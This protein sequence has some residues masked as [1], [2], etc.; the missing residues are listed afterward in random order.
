MLVL[1]VFEGHASNTQT[2]GPLRT[3]VTPCSTTGCTRKLTK[4]DVAIFID[5]PQNERL[6]PS[7]EGNN[8]KS[9]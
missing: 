8:G 5:R 1:F 2:Q 7:Q 9:P 4:L 3:P 6:G